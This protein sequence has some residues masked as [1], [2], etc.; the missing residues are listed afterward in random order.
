M[1]INP[2]LRLSHLGLRHLISNNST[3]QY[4]LMHK[5]RLPHHITY[6]GHPGNTYFL[7]Q[8]LSLLLHNLQP[9]L[10]QRPHRL[11]S[12]ASTND[13]IAIAHVEVEVEVEVKIEVEVAEAT[14]R[15]ITTQKEVQSLRLMVLIR[16]LS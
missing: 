16:V 12:V 9:H 2:H 7:P 11:T 5:L 14:R 1:G 6:N 10:Y 4:P 15:R 8:R 3:S 13:D